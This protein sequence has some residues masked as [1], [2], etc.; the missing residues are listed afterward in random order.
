M[1][2][3]TG[4]HD[5]GRGVSIHLA[6]SCTAEDRAKTKTIVYGVL[7]GQGIEACPRNLLQHT[8]HTISIE[9]VCLARCHDGSV[10]ARNRG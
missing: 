6:G 10:S 5:I 8:K 4:L 7:Y 9:Y 3:G 2:I 1:D